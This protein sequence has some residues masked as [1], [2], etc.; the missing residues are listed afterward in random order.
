MAEEPHLIGNCGGAL[1]VGCAV[2]ALVD[3]GGSGA[4]RR[5]TIIAIRAVARS[6]DLSLTVVHR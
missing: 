4:Y 2:E 3:V 6:G 1:V 5:G